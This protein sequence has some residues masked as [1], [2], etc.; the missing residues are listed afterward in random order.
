MFI[1][2]SS[3]NEIALTKKNCVHLRVQCD[4]YIWNLKRDEL[5]K[6][7]CNNGYSF[8]IEKNC[9]FF[10]QKCLNIPHPTH[11]PTQ[12]PLHQRIGSKSYATFY[13]NRQFLPFISLSH[14]LHHLSP[15]RHKNRALGQGNKNRNFGIGKIWFEF[16]RCHVVV[17]RVN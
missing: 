1:Y 17:S 7:E 4:H 6:A 13:L 15:H 12:C 11:S 9:T 2:F 3:F 14:T 5:T 10:V 8:L 16:Y